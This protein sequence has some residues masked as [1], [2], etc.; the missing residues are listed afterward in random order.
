MLPQDT[1]STPPVYAPF[2]VPDAEDTALAVSLEEGGVAINDPSEGRQVQ[3]WRAWVEGGTSVRCGP[4]PDPEPGTE[5]FV[6][7]AIT[8]VSI[9]WD[10]TMAPTVAYFDEGVLKLRWYNSLTEAFQTD[11]YTG[12]TSGKV[13]TDDKRSSIEGSSD[14]IFAYTLDGVLYWRQQRDRYLIEYT[15]GP[16][17]VQVLRTIGMNSGNRFQFELV[18]P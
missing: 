1:V 18:N 15:A 14:V 2:L 5:L 9:A 16:S 8:A 11:D 4:E 7:V 13:S 17:G 10:T 6:G 12:C 3:T